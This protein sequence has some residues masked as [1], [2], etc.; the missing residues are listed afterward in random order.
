[1]ISL[2][3]DLA[4]VAICSDC[5]RE[6]FDPSSRRYRYPFLSCSHCGGRLTIVKSLPG[7]RAQTSMSAFSLCA[8]CEREFNDPT[9]RYHEAQN[10]S[11]PACGPKVWLEAAEFVSFGVESEHLAE[12]N[13]AISSARALLTQGKIL[14]VKDLGGFYLTCD[15]C[16]AK[17]VSGLRQ[18]KLRVD[19]PFTVIMPDVETVK[20]HCFLSDTERELLQSPQRPAVILRRRA[21]SSIVPDVAPGQNVLYVKLPASPLSYLLL[22]KS[23]AFPEALVMIPANLA[24]EPMVISNEEARERLLSLADAYLMHDLEIQ[25]RCD[26]SVVRALEAEDQS[27][28]LIYPVRLSRGYA[29]IALPLPFEMPPVLACGAETKSAFCLTDGEQAVISHY[30]GEMD[31]YETLRFF[32]Q[33]LAHYENLFGIRPEVL[34]HD[35]NPDFLSTRYALQRAEREGLRTLA[36]QHQHAHVAACMAENALDGSRPVIGVVFT[37]RGYHEDGSIWGGEFLL[38]DYAGFQRLLHL[39]QFPLPGG[40]AAVK[41]TA[42]AAMALLHRFDVEW[43]EDLPPFNEFCPGGRSTLRTQLEKNINVPPTSSVGRL[44]DAVSSIAGVRQQ[45]NYEAQAAIEFEALADPDED[46]AYAFEVN[47]AEVGMRT[48]VEALTMDVLRGV[49]V[50]VISARFHN[51]VAR[52]VAEACSKL[53]VATGINEVVLSGGVWENVTLLRK[54]LPLL[55]EAGFQIYLHRLLPPNDGGLSLGQAVAAGWKLARSRI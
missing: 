55:R 49:P 17:A 19:K 5:L 8:D 10:V 32:E 28:S 12:G 34:A 45:V 44:F 23:D 14:A 4:D 31:S 16:D 26:D 9:S 30:I 51:G 24:N 42:R 21:D 41:K 37:G 50:P 18:R 35:S 46:G 54:T 38:A 22:E 11:C 15:A 36:V 52:M 25:M 39:E 27:D 2:S 47:Q 48:A 43:T 7:D 3:V 1:M 6:L 20:K 13:A 29:P 40:E 53:R 33:T